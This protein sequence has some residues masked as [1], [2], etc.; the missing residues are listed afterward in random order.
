MCT[1]YEYT[2]TLFVRAEVYCCLSRRFGVHF[3]CCN[4]TA[5]ATVIRIVYYYDTM[6]LLYAA[7]AEYAILRGTGDTYESD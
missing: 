2:G 5:V 3:F 4:Y 1:V 7:P 6:I